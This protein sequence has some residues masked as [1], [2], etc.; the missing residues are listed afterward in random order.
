MAC[1]VRLNDNTAQDHGFGFRYPVQYPPTAIVASPSRPCH[2]CVVH[3]FERLAG[4]LV[5]ARP[6]DRIALRE[7]YEFVNGCLALGAR[8]LDQQLK[9]LERR[10]AALLEA[11]NLAWLEGTTGTPSEQQRLL[12]AATSVGKSELVKAL[13][14]RIRSHEQQYG[15]AS[16][17]RPKLG[18]WR[19]LTS[20]ARQVIDSAGRA[21]AQVLQRERRE[22]AAGRRNQEQLG[23]RRSEIAWLLRDEL[24]PDSP[25]GRAR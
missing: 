21:E 13:V 9:D 20:S 24:L 3:L 14:Q 4:V 11:R 16:W 22:L 2:C 5:R 1:A 7:E 6:D 23:E 15:K 8:I 17:Q 19:R 10:E 25:T 12:R 18:D